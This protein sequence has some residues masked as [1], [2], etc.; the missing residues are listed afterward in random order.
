MSYSIDL[1]L[2]KIFVSYS[3]ADGRFVR[4]LR[5]RLESHGY[6][7]WLDEKELVAGDPL[8]HR[9]SEGIDDA[10]VVLVIVS[11]ASVRSKWLRFEVNHATE[12]M[13]EGKCRIIPI[14]IDSAR[15]PSEVSG[16]LYADFRKSFK[17]GVHSVVTALSYEAAAHH[18]FFYQV[19][20]PIVVS[21]FGSKGS[22]ATVGGYQSD[23]YNFIHVTSRST[24]NPGDMDVVYDTVEDYGGRKE[25]LDPRFWEE[26]ATVNANRT[27]TLSLLITQ[28]PIEFPIDSIWAGDPNIGVREFASN[29]VGNTT[30]AAVLVDMS[31]VDGH[32]EQVRL[33]QQA[34][35]FLVFLATE[36]NDSP[37]PDATPPGGSESW[38]G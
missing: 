33:V 13:V 2:G 10:K 12:R 34:K 31:S 16:L 29:I 28:R 24:S 27:E 35:E 25:P 7:I 11:E 9:I 26:Y 22:S 3:H 17:D 14:I 21:V 37:G 18:K 30:N 5:N 36:Q 20:D 1:V 38:R 32:E 23:E 8:S 6:R 15:L 4:R 19:I